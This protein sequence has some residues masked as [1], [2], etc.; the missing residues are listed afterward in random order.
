MIDFN[1]KL[2][3]ER[4]AREKVQKLK[5]LSADTFL[6]LNEINTIRDI[7]V[8]KAVIRLLLTDAAQSK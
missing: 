1:R 3:I 5:L 6:V 7:D 8:A 2:Q 4:E